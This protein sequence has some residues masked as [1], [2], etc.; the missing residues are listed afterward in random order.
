MPANAVKWGEKLDVNIHKT[1]K[2]LAFKRKKGNARTNAKK[3]NNT[4]LR[5]TPGVEYVPVLDL[6]IK[7]LSTKIL[8]CLPSPHSTW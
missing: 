4:A 7:K 5:E 8:G 3:S 1:N 6:Q 2:V